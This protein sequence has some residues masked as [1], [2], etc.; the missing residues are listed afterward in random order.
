M[1]QEEFA[2]L[3]EEFRRKAKL[4]EERAPCISIVDF[5]ECTS[6]G[7]RYRWWLAHAQGAGFELLYDPSVTKA[8]VEEAKRQ[9]R[10]NRDV[11]QML[12]LKVDEYIELDMS[13]ILTSVPA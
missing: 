5:D 13:T 11:V 1:G 9:I 10:G 2:R 7:V 12:V 6:G 3:E 4:S 8:Q